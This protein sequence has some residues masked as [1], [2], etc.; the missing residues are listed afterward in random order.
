MIYNLNYVFEVKNVFEI[1]RNLFFNFYLVDLCVSNFYANFVTGAGFLKRTF[2]T[3]VY[4][5]YFSPSFFTHPN[6]LSLLQKKRLLSAKEQYQT[7][8]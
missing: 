8:G 1:K 2:A 7:Q 3:I 6:F 4:S 5:S